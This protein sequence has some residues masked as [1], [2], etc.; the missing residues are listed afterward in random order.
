MKKYY[1]LLLNCGRRR[2]RFD[3]YSEYGY[4]EILPQKGTEEKKGLFG[5]KYVP[6]TTY[7]GRYEVIAE[8]VDDHFEDI[9]LNKRIEYDTDGVKDIERVTIE[10]LEAELD[11]GLTC[12]HCREIQPEIATYYKDKIEKDENMLKKYISELTEI[13]TKINVLREIEKRNQTSISEEQVIDSK[14]K[15]ILRK[16]KSA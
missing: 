10:E 16:K 9:I 14:P 6:V 3:R 8:L 7:T 2:N 15:Q 12:Y 13:E 11:K 4:I 5:P 1:R